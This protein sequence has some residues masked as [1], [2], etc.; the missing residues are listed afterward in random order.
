MAVIFNAK[1]TTSPYF[2]L[3][4]GGTTLY[5]G[6]SDPTGSYSASAGDVWFDTNAN[7]LKFRNSGN[8]AWEQGSIDIT[9]NATISGNLTVNGT[10]TIIDTT[11]TAIQDPLLLLSRGTTGTPTQDSGFVIERGDSAN[12]ALVWDESADEF[13][14]INTTEAGTTAGNVSIA[15][16]ANIRAD[17]YYG[18]GS[19]LTGVVS[20][21]SALTDTTISNPADNEFLRYTGSAWVNEAVTL[22]S[23]VAALTD[24][25]ISGPSSGQVLKYNGSAWINDAD[26]ATTTVTLS[27][28]TG[29]GSDTTLTLEATPSSDDNLL[30]FV[31]SVLQDAG[32]WSRSGTTLTFSEAP[33]NGAVIKAWD[34]LAST[35]T[36]AAKLDALTADG[37]TVAFTLQQSSSD[38]TPSHANCLLVSVAGV[39]QEPGAGKAFTV[40]GSTITFSTA[41]ATGAT[42]W[43]V[44]VGGGVTVNTP[45]DDSVTSAKIADDAV[46]ADKLSATGTASS[47]TYLR[48]DMAWGTIPTVFPFFKANGSADN[49]T[50][51]NGEFPFYKADGNADNI[52][53]S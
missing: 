28:M 52:G 36:N 43:I 34:L 51:T 31:D 8:S 27:E 9:G 46:T 23:T 11:N 32:A 17:E 4:K 22:T 50:I 16:Y 39:L 6:S 3:G 24:T 49:I 13:A 44:D 41:P 15:S 5:Q 1:G 14:V 40:S 2:L 10:T 47:S 29:D 12:V 21:L 38:Y 25:T 42:I 35:A 18:D 26:S 20:T 37:E 19:N 30:V 45:A 48:G 33:A 53:V 7:T